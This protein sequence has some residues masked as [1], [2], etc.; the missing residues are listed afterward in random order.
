MKMINVIEI[1]H[2]GSV[3]G[4]TLFSGMDE[5]KVKNRAKK[6]FCSRCSEVFG[7]EWDK[8]KE[9]WKEFYTES[10]LFDAEEYAD[11]FEIARILINNPQVKNVK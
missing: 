9:D 11:N 2:N 10:G 4:N 6:H 8:I 3:V 7:A 5:E 1:D